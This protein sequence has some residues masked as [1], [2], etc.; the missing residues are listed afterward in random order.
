MNQP[1]SNK[2]KSAWKKLAYNKVLQ[3]KDFYISYNPN[4]GIGDGSGLSLLIATIGESFGLDRGTE[5]TALCFKG[6]TRNVFLILLGDFRKEYEACG[7]SLEEAKK[8]FEKYKPAHYGN[9]STTED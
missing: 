6:K 2:K 5:E 3:R 7:E 4:T 8:V 1:S 9:W